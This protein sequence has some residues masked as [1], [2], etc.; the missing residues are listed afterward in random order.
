[1]INK[2][3]AVRQRLP[4]DGGGGSTG[5]TNPVTGDIEFGPMISNI[6]SVIIIIAFLASFFYLLW[7]G[8]QWITSGGNPEQVDAAR[9]R[10]MQALVGL[11]VVVAA[12]AIMG[13]VSAFFGVDFTSFNIPTL[14]G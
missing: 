11:V 8:V 10:I 1:M 3:F 7:G 2:V 13:L 5:I 4:E 14:G 12:W 9:N 6:I